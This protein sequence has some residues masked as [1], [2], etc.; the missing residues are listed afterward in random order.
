MNDATLSP[1]K[2][3]TCATQPAG[4]CSPFE[5]LPHSSA[6][7]YMLETLYEMYLKIKGIGGKCYG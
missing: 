1:N 7:S 6:I 4:G 2:A 5:I 3:Y